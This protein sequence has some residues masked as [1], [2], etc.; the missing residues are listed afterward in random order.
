MPELFIVL[1]T[2]QLLTSSGDAAE[3]TIPLGES[4]SSLIHHFRTVFIT[5]RVLVC[6]MGVLLGWFYAQF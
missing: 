4:G 2:A 5:G 6:E 3:G 1:H